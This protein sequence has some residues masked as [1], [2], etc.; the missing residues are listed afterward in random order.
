MINAIAEKIKEMINFSSEDSLIFNNKIL[1]IQSGYFAPIP[2]TD[3]CEYE[4]L[5]DGKTIAFIDGGQAEILAAGNF[6]LSFIRVVALVFQDNKNTACIKKEFY[7]LTTAKYVDNDLYYESKI[8]GDKLIDESDL[9]ISSND[10]TITVGMERA[11]ISKVSGMARRFAELSLAAEINADFKV[12]DGTL[13][14]T[15]KNEQKYIGLL[16][17]N[18]CALAKSSSLFTTSG[19]SPVV[20]LNKLGPQ[21]CWS[22]FVEKKSFFVKL[23][24]QAKHVFRFEG[25][26]DVLSLLKKNSSDALLLG[27]PYGLI[28]V[29]KLARVTHHEQ[30]SLKMQFL[31]NEKNKDISEYLN[32]V[33]VHDFLDN[34]G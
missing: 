11:P 10:R 12:I 32:T 24:E 29:D 34:L 6:S 25:N 2:Q 31:L 7:L 16:P 8:F 4:K 15:F 22:Y 27:Y 19:N 26:L 21:G 28:A 17:E 5:T 33:N 3:F 13:K 9:L 23:H 20:L 14:Q 1:P 18:V 30:N